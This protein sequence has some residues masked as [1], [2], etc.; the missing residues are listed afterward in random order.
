MGWTYFKS[1][2]LFFKIW[3]VQVNL[4]QKVLFLHQLTQQIVHRITSS[5]HENFKLKPG[6]NML[7]TEIVSDI[8]NNICTHHVLPTLLEIP[9]IQISGKNFVTSVYGWKTNVSNAKCYTKVFPPDV[10]GLNFDVYSN[11]L[12]KSLFL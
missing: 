4:C 1:S 7:C 9:P 3:I 11:Y 6:K 5:I 8:Q 12:L 10:K 2:I